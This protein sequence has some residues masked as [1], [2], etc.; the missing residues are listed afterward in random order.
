MVVVGQGAVDYVIRQYL[1]HYHTERNHQ[2]L[3]NQLLVREQAGGDHKGPV[4]RRARLGG[5][6][7]YYYREAA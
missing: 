6:L 3:D 1:S 7:S 5:L 4:G 2:G